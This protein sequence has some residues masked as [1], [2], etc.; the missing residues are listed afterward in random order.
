MSLLGYVKCASGAPN[1]L[2]PPSGSPGGNRGWEKP[3]RVPRH[4]LANTPATNI[5]N[6]LI[7]KD[8]CGTRQ[9]APTAKAV[10]GKTD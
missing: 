2:S 6:C 3:E 1:E 9:P 7:S 5:N 8:P 10:T 4:T